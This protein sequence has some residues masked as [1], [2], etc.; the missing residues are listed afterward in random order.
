MDAKRAA[1]MFADITGDEDYIIGTPKSTVEVGG[2]SS[3][4][5]QNRGVD[6]ATI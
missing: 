2:P 5:P 4:A 1:M 6:Q 3:V